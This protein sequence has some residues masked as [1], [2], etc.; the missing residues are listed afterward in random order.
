MSY[1]LG[2][3]LGTSSIKGLLVNQKGEVVS[4]VSHNYPVLIPQAG[5]SEQDPTLWIEATNNILQEMVQKVPDMSSELEGISFS[6]QMH[7]LVLL[8]E[9]GTVIRN[10]ILWNDVRTTEQCKYLMKHYKEQLLEITKNS[11][12]EG[13]TLPKILWVQENEPENWEHT[14]KF[15][16][17]KDYLAYYLTGKMQMDLSDAAGTLLLDVQSEKWSDE[18]MNAFS[19]KEEVMP[20]L[21][22]STDL[23]GELRE[24]LQEKF[25]FQQPVKIFGGGADNACAA[26]GAGIVSEDIALASIGTSGVFL[27]YENDKTK[28]Y[29]GKLHLF[30]HVLNDAV[31][32]MGVTLAAGDSLSWFKATFAPN[33]PFEQL[34]NDIDTV[35][36]GSDGL[37]FT[38]YIAGERT[39]YVD[40]QIRGSFIGIDRNHELKHFTRSVLEGIT[41]SLRDSQSLMEKVAGKTFNKIVSVGGGAKNHDWLQMQADIFET[42]VVTL[43]TEQGPGLGAAMLAALGCG[44]FETVE[45]CVATFVH[46]TEEYLPNEK[47]VQNY[48]EIYKIYQEIYGVTANLTHQLQKCR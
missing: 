23:R 47:H 41:F 8:D 27:S 1:V 29:Q 11:A 20:E 6:G 21:I 19:L 7:S 16:L 2:L 39:P 30:N 43:T 31:Y 37:I 44:W 45:D 17:P 15:L 48:R 34:L 35:P 5:Y 24:E 13:F 22:S 25:G 26:L 12:L 46:Y 40:S 9:S 18:L 33:S 42:P 36:P 10:A 38:P 28:S 4:C 3:D 32:S 14:A